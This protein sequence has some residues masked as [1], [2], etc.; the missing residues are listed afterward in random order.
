MFCT[1]EKKFKK[2][3]SAVFPALLKSC[4]VTKP[5]EK[6][7]ILRNYFSHTF[8]NALLFCSFKTRIDTPIYL[9]YPVFP[10]YNLTPSPNT[11]ILTRPPPP[12][13]H[14]PTHLAPREISVEA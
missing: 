3:Q 9:I 1:K 13:R 14:A 7:W 5:T 8:T 6:Y 10:Q 4:S 11:A 12:L 2:L